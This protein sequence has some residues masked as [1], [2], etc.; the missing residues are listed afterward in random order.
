M[1]RKDVEVKEEETICPH[2]VAEGPTGGCG[3]ERLVE[4]APAPRDPCR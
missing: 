2:E 3:G 4:K 1:G